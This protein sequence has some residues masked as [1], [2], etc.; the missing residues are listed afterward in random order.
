[1]LDAAGGERESGQLAD[2]ER[3]V[4]SGTAEVGTASIG[5]SPGGQERRG[6][7][8]A[9]RE[10][11]EGGPCAPP[12]HVQHVVAARVGDDPAVAAAPQ[13]DGVGVDLG[14]VGV[15]LRLVAETSAAMRGP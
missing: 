3:A 9:G 2:V 11:P 13:P 5:M 15:L 14:A 6:R 8:E 12:A 10:D 7:H 4:G 1:M